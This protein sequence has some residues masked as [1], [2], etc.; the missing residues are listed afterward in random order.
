MLVFDTE[1]STTS[2]EEGANATICIHISSDASVL[3]FDL[4]VTLTTV[5]DKAIG[6]NSVLCSKMTQVYSCYVNLAYLSHNYYT[7]RMVNIVGER[8]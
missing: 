2:V 7:R 6:N 1:N 5:N 8:E 3:G 4:T